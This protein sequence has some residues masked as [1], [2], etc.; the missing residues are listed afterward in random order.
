MT[1]HRERDHDYYRVITEINDCLR[2]I[3]CCD[4]IQ[5]IL[6]KREGKRDVKPRW[7][8]VSYCTTRSA[9]IRVTLGKCRNF[10]SGAM[11]CLNALPEKIEQTEND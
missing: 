10:K 8:G 7:T 4:G 11:D 2:V 3:I 6:Q 5:W 9:L 1:S